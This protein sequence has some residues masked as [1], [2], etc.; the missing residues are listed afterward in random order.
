MKILQIMAGARHGGAETCFV[1]TVL[2]LHRAGIEQTVLIRR[3]AARA[4]H[5][6]GAGLKVEE[7]GFGSPYL[8]VLTH[9]RVRRTIES[10]RPDAVMAWMQRA[11]AFLPAGGDRKSVV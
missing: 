6:R 7:A 5:V 9:W 1:D 4:A 2:A 8:D 3:D 11:A 10:E